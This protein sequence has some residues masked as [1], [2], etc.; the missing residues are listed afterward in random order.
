MKQKRE[1]ENKLYKQSNDVQERYRDHSMEKGH[2][3]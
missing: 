1:P 3:F 2:S